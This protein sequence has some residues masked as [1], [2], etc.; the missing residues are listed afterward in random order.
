MRAKTN[1]ESF[2][3]SNFGPIPRG[4]QSCLPNCQ[5]HQNHPKKNLLAGLFTSAPFRPGTSI[6]IKLQPWM[7]RKAFIPCISSRLKKDMVGTKVP[8]LV[9]ALPVRKSDTFMV[10]DVSKTAS[11]VRDSRMCW[12]LAATF[13]VEC[14]ASVRICLEN[15][16][17][18]QGFLSARRR[19]LVHSW[20]ASI[21]ILFTSCLIS[22]HLH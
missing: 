7:P 17:M 21:V 3:P 12:H 8:V 18:E 5:E 11:S 15:I 19:M 14:V 10:S 16:C 13:Q 20:V 4:N 1:E 22:A 6:H 9:F 2:G